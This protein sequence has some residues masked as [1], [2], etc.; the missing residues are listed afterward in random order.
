MMKRIKLSFVKEHVSA[1][2]LLLE[3]NAPETCRCIWD[4]LQEPLE[5]NAVHAMWTGREL[6]YPIPADKFPD[7]EG[8]K[9]PPENQ[10]VIPVPGD[11]IWNA[12]APYQWQG[13]PKPIYDFGI[14]YGRDSRLL[15]PVGWR[16]SN[17]FGCIIENLDPFAA[18]C[19]RCQREGEKRIRLERWEH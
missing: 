9:V 3:D 5:Q 16:P 10:T 1:I 6:S 14:F 4:L 12:Y 19:A 17:R 15:L 2:A 13:N 11:L 8:L 7:N 18:V